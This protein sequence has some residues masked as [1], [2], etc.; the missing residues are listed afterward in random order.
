MDITLKINE[1][2]V[3]AFYQWLDANVTTHNRTDEALHALQEDATTMAGLD[4]AMPSVNVSEELMQT[5]EPYKA[6]VRPTFANIDTLTLQSYFQV[7]VDSPE[8]A[9][10][11]AQ[12]LRKLEGID[13]A[14][15]KPQDELPIY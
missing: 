4:K 10:Q 11:V 12:E 9:E 7:T 1:T 2:L 8:E 5:L 3:P 15:I 14:Y 6:G 13:A